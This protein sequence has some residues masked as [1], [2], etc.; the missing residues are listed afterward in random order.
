LADRQ[1]S[2]LERSSRYKG[3]LSPKQHGEI[4]EALRRSRMLRAENALADRQRTLMER[5][6]RCKVTLLPKQDGEL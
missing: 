4:G 5:S 2:F 1:R 3:T 6:S